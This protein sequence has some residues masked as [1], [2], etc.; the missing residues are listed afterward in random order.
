MICGMRYLKN[1]KRSLN[2]KSLPKARREQLR[3]CAFHAYQQK[4]TAYATA[5]ELNL[6]ECLNRDVKAGLAEHA[7]PKDAAAVKRA[8]VSH[9]EKRKRDP[10]AVKRLFHKKEVR[11]A[12]EEE[13]G[14]KVSHED[15]PIVSV[16]NNKLGGSRSCAT[17]T[18][19][20]ARPSLFCFSL[21]L[22]VESY[23]RH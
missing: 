3:A 12:A 7:L 9:L 19:W 13:E 15:T 16:Q 10:E 4:K 2:V 23:P 17:E 18:R 1:R 21:R 5:K 22:C 14:G 11:Y 8:V 20:R 6:N